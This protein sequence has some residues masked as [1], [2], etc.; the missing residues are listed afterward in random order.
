MKNYVSK[1]GVTLAVFLVTA[2]AIAGI[3]GYQGSTRLGLMGKLK[4]STGMTCTKS[5]DYMVL[6]SASP[7]FTLANGEILQ[8]STDDVVEVLSDDNDTTF[9]ITGF[10][11]KSANINLYADQGDDNADKFSLNV[12]A[13]DVFSIQNNAV[14]KWSLSSAGVVSLADSETVT[15]AS[16][17][18]TFGFDDAAADVRINAFEATDAKLTLQADESDDS[19]DDWQVAS[20]TTNTF[21]IS[22]DTTGSQVAKFTMDTTGNVTA[23]GTGAMSGFL[24]AQVAA[25]ATTITVDQCGKTFYNTGA[26]AINLP[27]G[28][29]AV[30]GCRITF[31]TLNASN[32]DINPGN[33]DRIT[34]LTDADGDAIRNATIGNAITLQYAATNKWIYINHEGTWTDVN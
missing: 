15:D 13:A 14:A 6:T 4:C 10:E 27:A 34:T 1:L 22:N 8:N 11:A 26:V 17:V 33:S 20:T 5:G 31:I 9:Q 2:L 25:T 29:A 12:S 3:D 19:G 30:L 32:F 23:P 16:D 21:T 28:A 24:Q 7:S 18:L